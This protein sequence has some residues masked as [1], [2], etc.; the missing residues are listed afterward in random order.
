LRSLVGVQIV[1][2]GSYVPERVVTNEDLASLGCDADWIVQRTGIRERRHAPEGATT[3]DLAVAAAKR[4]LASARVEPKDVDL[5]VLATMS[6]DRLLPAT[7][8][9]VQHKLGVNCAAMDVSA[10]CAGFTYALFTA[11][12]FVGT[13]CSKR[14]LVIGADANSRVV[15]PGDIKT[16]PLFGA[17]AGAVLLA[18][19]S[20][21]QGALA[22]TLGSDGSGIDLLHRPVGGAER[23][24]RA[25]GPQDG[26]W[27]LQMEGRPVFKWAVRVVDESSRQVLEAVGVEPRQVAWWIFHQ[28]NVRIL[29]AAVEALEIDRE[30][31]VMHMDRYGNTSAGSIPLALDETLRAGKIRRGDLVVM[32]GF[33]AGL[34]WGTA[35]WRW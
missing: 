23:P 14:A 21:E 35:A 32:S 7:A 15:D 27:F 34:T 1:G 13:G 29:D 5:L 2:T 3:S 18:P 33:G 10:A 6:P 4:C 20:P 26:S 12:Q 16:Y 19:G 22:Y 31:V 17:G 9:A 25:Q 30:R 24:F 11:M 28:A 8:T